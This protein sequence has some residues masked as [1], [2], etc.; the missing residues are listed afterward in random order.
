MARVP[1]PLSTPPPRAKA[2][3]SSAF[4]AWTREPALK[5]LWTVAS[6]IGLRRLIRLLP[7]AYTDTVFFFEGAGVTGSVALTIDDGLAKNGPAAS[8]VNEVRAALQRH[9]AHATFFVCSRYLEGL[10]HEAAALVAEGHELGNHMAED[11]HFHYSSLT[12]GAFDVELQSVSATIEAVPGA[13]VRWFR[14]PQGLL[15]EKMA[16]V[17]RRRGLRHA[18]GDAYADD[19]AM[20]QSASF[21]AR[22]LL[23]QA[24]AGSILILH[25][26]E[27]G[28]REHTLDV[29][30][31]VLEGLTA[32]GLKC[33]TLSEL[34]DLAS[35]PGGA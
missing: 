8:M 26:P 28:W 29:L 15:S 35:R 13:R 30:H 14:A 2:V 33:V 32:R 6:A 24:T 3:S 27:R 16:A 19:W 4:V 5:A 23:R 34:Q 7:H 11:R 17:L 12:E 25:Q 21:V 10:E 22:T 20:P 9:S 31:E 1:P 18:L